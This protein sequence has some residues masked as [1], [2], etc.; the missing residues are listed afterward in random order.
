M[1]YVQLCKA[2]GHGA[3]LSSAGLRGRAG[4]TLDLDMW[5][6]DSAQRPGCARLYCSECERFSRWVR[7]PTE[8]EKRRAFPVPMYP[9]PPKGWEHGCPRCDRRSP[10]VSP[11]P[12]PEGER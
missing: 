8:A 6:V 1:T 2:D 9:H 7:V 3:N 5:T 4:V 10:R 11:V 12:Y